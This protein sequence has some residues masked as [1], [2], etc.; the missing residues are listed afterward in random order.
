MNMATPLPFEVWRFDATRRVRHHRERTEYCISLE[1]VLSQ[2]LL[3]TQRLYHVLWSTVHIRMY[4]CD[5][6][7]A[8]L[9]LDFAYA[10]KL[11]W[12]T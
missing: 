1:E 4:V 6:D 12:L 2:V 11:L 5:H 7:R 9:T 10:K 3:Y 8:S